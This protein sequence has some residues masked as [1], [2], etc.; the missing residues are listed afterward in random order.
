MGWYPKDNPPRLKQMFLL[1]AIFAAIDWASAQH[2]VGV[3]ASYTGDWGAYGVAYRHGIELADVGTKAT[4]IYEDDGFLPA[5]AVS[6]YRKLV[7]VDKISD[8]FVGDT[9]TAQAV[10]PIALKKKMPLFAWASGDRVFDTNPYAV[11]LWSTNKKDLSFITEQLKRHGYKR[12]ALFTSTHTYTTEW[13]RGLVEAFP[14]SVWE[15]FS[16]SPDSFQSNL[17]KAK[18]QGFDAIGVCLSSGLNGRLA[19]QMRDL[20]IGIPLFGCN[21][22]EASADIQAAA[23]ALDGVW[24]TAPKLSREF[25]NRYKGRYGTTDHVVSAA[26]FHD[27]ALLA[28]DTKDKPYAIS[29]L[30]EVNDSGD[31]HLEFEFDVL[32]FKGSEIV[33]EGQ[34]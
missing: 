25:V 14:G 9:V 8:V 29:G 17:L 32:R 10:A 28:T 21:F 5:K 1:V 24:F 34:P 12:L 18:N 20:K 13:G 7:D 27:A 6:A 2:K 19:K 31:R 11:R 4:F 26:I 3:L 22:L 16:A 33:V 30:R 15:D 23:G